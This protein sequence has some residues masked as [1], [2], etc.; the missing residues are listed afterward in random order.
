MF[1]RL[2]PTR[3]DRYHMAL[4][5]IIPAIAAFYSILLLYYRTDL[6]HTISQERLAP[7]W[8]R[9]A[10][11]LDEAQQ[12]QVQQQ[13][14][15]LEA[16][17]SIVP[18]QETPAWQGDADLEAEWRTLW[19]EYAPPLL[20]ATLH[21]P[22]QF[23]ET[24]PLLDR[25]L[26]VDGVH[27][28]EQAAPETSEGH[29]SMQQIILRQ[30]HLIVFYCLLLALATLA[31]IL[32]YP[33]RF[34]RQFVVRTGLGGAGSFVNPEQLWLRFTGLHMG[35]GLLVYLLFFLLGYLS[36][37]LASQA[38]ANPSLFTI[39]LQG[40]VTTLALTAGISLI[41]WW[42]PAPEVEALRVLR[43]SAFGGR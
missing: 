5:L 3:L 6:G 39:V 1:T 18:E 24:G 33:V 21:N 36:F 26:A 10:P 27:E 29:L 30:S 37:P 25:I 40:S 42:M 19:N 41:G 35:L 17:Q 7:L 12:A 2:I 15:S 22:R 23:D 11:E 31:L 43:P 20:L 28:V 16:I 38:G 9:L 32:N 13:L 4:L 14:A 8:I 34:R